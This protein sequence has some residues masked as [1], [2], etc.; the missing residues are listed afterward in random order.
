MRGLRAWCLH[1][2]LWLHAPTKVGADS[3]PHPPFPHR[4][5]VDM[6]YAQEVAG[7]EPGVYARRQGAARR[8]RP[9]ASADVASADAAESSDGESSSDEGSNAG[10]DAVL[11]AAGGTGGAAGVG[12]G[13]LRLNVDEVD[14][15]NPLRPRYTGGCA[16]AACRPRPAAAAGPCLAWRQQS[17]C[18]GTCPAPLCTLLA[19]VWRFLRPALNL[20]TLR[21]M[22]WWTATS[23]TT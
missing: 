8:Q 13:R 12:G 6:G 14:R 20:Q 16:C 19:E 15:D 7:G 4:R 9:D 2:T 5:L 23:R 1:H 18:P 11:A 17:E 22:C 3:A 21:A 10:L